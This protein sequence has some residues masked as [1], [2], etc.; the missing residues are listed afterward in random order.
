MTSLLS[1][2]CSFAVVTVLWAFVSFSLS[3]LA[4]DLWASKGRCDC[5]LLRVINVM[6]PAGH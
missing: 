1:L 2:C 6:E 5:L 3:A 4:C